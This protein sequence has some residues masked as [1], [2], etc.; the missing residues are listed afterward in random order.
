MARG[1]ADWDIVSPDYFAT[2]EMDIVEGRAFTAADRDGTPRVT[3]IN[4]TF[5][6]Q[7]L[8]GPIGHRPKR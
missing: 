7:A 2:I 8:A 3:I 5:A 4:E 6:R 1:E